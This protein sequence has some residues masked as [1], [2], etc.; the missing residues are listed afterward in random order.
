MKDYFGVTIK[1]GN[2]V[3][4]GKSSRENPLGVGI[5]RS[6]SETSMEVLGHGCSKVGTIRK[7]ARDTFN[8]RVVVLP[9][10]YGRIE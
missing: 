3:V 1:A 6:V 8:R 5:V 4:Y 2:T 10:E 9:E 7:N